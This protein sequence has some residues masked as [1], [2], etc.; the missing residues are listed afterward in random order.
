MPTYVFECNKCG[1]GFEVILPM[2]QYDTPQDCPECSAPD[3]KRL[4]TCTNFNLVGDDWPGKSIR[5]TGQMKKKHENMAPRVAEKKREEPLTTLIP[6]VE[7][8]VTDSWEDAQ[9]LAASKGKAADSFE[10]LVHKERQGGL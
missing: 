3:A 1:H 6:N 7:G 2:K 10:P 9:K 8:E 4:V 5:V